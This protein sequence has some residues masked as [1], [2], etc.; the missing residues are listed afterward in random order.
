MTAAINYNFPFAIAKPFDIR[1]ERFSAFA[2][3]SCSYD[4]N[5]SS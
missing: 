1:K 4:P 5:M 3:R 2:A